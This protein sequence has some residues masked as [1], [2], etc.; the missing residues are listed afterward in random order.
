MEANHSRRVDP[1]SFSLLQKQ[2]HA[3]LYLNQPA[4]TLLDRRG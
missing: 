4:A 1:R 3:K 2:P